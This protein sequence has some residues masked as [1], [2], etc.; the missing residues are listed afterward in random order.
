VKSKSQEEEE[1]L[2]KSKSQEEEK[3]LVKSKSEEEEEEEET[4][5]INLGT[6]TAAV[7]VLLGTKKS[8]IYL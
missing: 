6:D 7:L 5:K 8:V 3:A 1:A 4:Q 2:V